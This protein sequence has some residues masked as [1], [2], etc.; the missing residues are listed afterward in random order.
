MCRP[1][2][3]RSCA[4]IRRRLRQIL[5]NLIGNAIK[6]TDQGGVTVAVEEQWRSDAEIRLHFSVLDTGV[7][8]PAVQLD[9]IFEAF[10]Q[11]DAS[12][13]C[14]Y[15]GSGLGLTI[16]SELVRMMKGRIWVQSAVG[17][18]STFHFTIH[19]KW[20]AAPAAVPAAI[21]EH[22]PC[23]LPRPTAANA[24]PPLMSTACARRLRI[25]VADDHDANRH[26]VTT[27]LTKRGHQCVE[28]SNGQQVLEA[29]ARQTLDAVLMDVQMPGM[30]G[31]QATAAIR[32][33]EEGEGGHVPIIAL[34]A[35]AMSG[36]RER[37][38]LA[39]MDAYLAKRL[40]PSELV[41]LVES[42]P[43]TTNSRSGAHP[44]PS[45]DESSASPGYDLH[46]ALASL[47]NDVDLLI[48]QMSF[49]VNDG[50]V[51]R[52]QIDQALQRH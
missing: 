37:C 3:R 14:K 6:F 27:V 36:D 32:K 44:L 40:R 50:P 18:G 22:M 17:Q 47:D 31:Y 42:L 13:T 34:T 11:G 4:V 35:H 46:A 49:F 15:G 1:A 45:T 23:A 5:L 24:A 21:P 51:L 33:R 12:T 41:Q 30:D 52:E 9:A 28:A 2:C 29:L 39:G 48:S 20:S 19:L 26:L 43:A 38:L 7:G 25:L 16:S 8:I 10:Q